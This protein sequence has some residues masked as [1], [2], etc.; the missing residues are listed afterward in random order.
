MFPA[1]Y[2]SLTERSRTFL[3]PLAVEKLLRCIHN[4][5]NVAITAPTNLPER[6]DYFQLG[7]AKGR[8]HSSLGNMHLPRP[9]S[10]S[11]T[12]LCTGRF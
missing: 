3:L 8:C 12:F 10:F 9:K 2:V 4:R 1:K 5:A 11:T 6:V 7:R